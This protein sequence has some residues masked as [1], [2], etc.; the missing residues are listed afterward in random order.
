MVAFIM[1]SYAVVLIASRRVASDPPVLGGL[2][3]SGWIFFF[4]DKGQ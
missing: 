2:V 4:V 3:L 1:I